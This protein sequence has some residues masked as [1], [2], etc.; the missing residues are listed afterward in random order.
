MRSREQDEKWFFR[1]VGSGE[2]FW[3]NH[4]HKKAVKEYP[5]LED[6]MREIK[7]FK[8]RYQTEEL[9]KHKKDNSLIKAIFR[10]HTEE[11]ALKLLTQEAQNFVEFYLAN[12]DLIEANSSSLVNQADTVTN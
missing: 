7:S 2:C 5:H 12:K 1:Y 11:T 3:V 4:E 10:K 6:L 8:Q 9:K